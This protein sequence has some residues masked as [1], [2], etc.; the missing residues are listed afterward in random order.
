LKIIQET[1]G[2]SRSTTTADLYTNV[3]PDRARAAAEATAAIVPRNRPV[4][5]VTC[6]SDPTAT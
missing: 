5:P 3:L 1:L 6:G 4:D 2:H